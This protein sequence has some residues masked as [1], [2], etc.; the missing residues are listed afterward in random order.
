MGK[1]KMLAQ[2]ITMTLLIGIKRSGQAPRRQFWQTF[3]SNRVL[4]GAGIAELPG[5]I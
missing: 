5:N 2:V 4:V 1:F 3:S